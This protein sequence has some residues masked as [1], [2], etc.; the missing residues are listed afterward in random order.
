MADD[1]KDK[2]HIILFDKEELE[3]R[4]GAHKL[5]KPISSAVK[6][7]LKVEPPSCYMT[8]PTM[9][10]IDTDDDDKNCGKHPPAPACY[11]PPLRPLDDDNE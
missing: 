2:D 8:G 10:D 5:K 6:K 4:L 11:A 3:K 1:K 9:D 7:F